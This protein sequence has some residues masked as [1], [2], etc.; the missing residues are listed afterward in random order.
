M[1][2]VLSKSS[3]KSVPS[4][5]A[6]SSKQENT[7]SSKLAYFQRVKPAKNKTKSEAEEASLAELG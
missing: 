5:M 1:L 4:F 2:S 6:L 7:R 3:S